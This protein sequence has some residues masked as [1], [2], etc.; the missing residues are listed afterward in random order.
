MDAE[1][2]NWFERA[3]RF[4]STNREE[5]AVL[6]ECAKSAERVIDLGNTE[7]RYVKLKAAS[8]VEDFNFYPRHSVDD[9]CVVDYAKAMEAGAIFPPVIVEKK[10]LRIVDGWKRTRAALK[11]GGDGAEIEVEFRTYKNDGEMLLDAISLNTV[12]GQRIER[13]D[14]Q[15][16]AILGDQF[17]L[18]AEKLAAAMHVTPEHLEK[19]RGKL[20]STRSGDVIANKQVGQELPLVITVRQAEGIKRAG[21]G[22]QVFFVNQVIN[23]IENNL[24]DTENE[25]LMERLAHLSDVLKPVLEKVSA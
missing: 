24:L 17:G 6:R 15:R 10:S 3:K 22:N 23:L 9:Y 16:C 7:R 4:D 21:G 1:S 12:H 5:R 11:H 14:L 8:L 19:I 20:R 18:S 25:R 13:Y 2:I